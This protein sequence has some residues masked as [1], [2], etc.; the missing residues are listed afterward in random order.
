MR[1]MVVYDSKHGNTERIAEAIAKGLTGSGVSSV[2]VIWVSKACE[3]D[4]HDIDLWVVGSP[5][6]WGGPTFK[7]RTLLSNAIR[8]EGK[9]R[10]FAVFD[11]RYEKVHTGASEKLR[12]I[13]A[14][15]GLTEVIEPEHF[16]VLGGNG[17]LKEGEESR[18]EA[19]GK[20][21]AERALIT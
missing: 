21:I 10:R 13:L 7:V 17:P 4:F 16:V 3:D 9:G 14:K 12:A 19:Y 18:A 5:T 1:A 8:Y 11:T 2:T 20:R 15:G 6:R